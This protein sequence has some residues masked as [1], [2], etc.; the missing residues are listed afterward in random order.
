MNLNCLFCHRDLAPKYKTGLVYAEMDYACRD[1]KATYHK[2]YLN[3]RLLYYILEDEPYQIKFYME[4]SPKACIRKKTY[5]KQYSYEF[6]I[7]VWLDSH[8]AITP[9]NISQKLKT[10]LIFS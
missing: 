10:Y 1:C 8:P 9:Q 6:Q 2:D 3:G 5:Y 7:I 4:G